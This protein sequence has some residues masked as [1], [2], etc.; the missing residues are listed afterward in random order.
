MYDYTASCELCSNW[1]HYS[2]EF[3]AIYCDPC[4]EWVTKKCSGLFC[5]KCDE[6]PRRPS[7]VTKKAKKELID[8][9]S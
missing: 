6:R 1:F 4:D 8:E 7:L 5:K 2:E 9:I 3:E